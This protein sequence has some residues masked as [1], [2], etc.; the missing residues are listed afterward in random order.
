MGLLLAKTYVPKKT[1]QTSFLYGSQSRGSE[2]TRCSLCPSA[3]ATFVALAWVQWCSPSHS[4]SKRMLWT[5]V[6]HPQANALVPLGCTLKSNRAG[7]SST[8]A[9]TV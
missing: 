1:A 4:R 3:L 2:R 8:A 5:K 6:R 7:Y 9:V